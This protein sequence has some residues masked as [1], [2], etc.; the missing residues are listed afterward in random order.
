ML[1]IPLIPLKNNFQN[2]SKDIKEG[3]WLSILVINIYPSD[4]LQNCI[5]QKDHENCK[6][7]FGAVYG[8][9]LPGP[10]SVVHSSMFLL[11]QHNEG[12]IDR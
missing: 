12:E 4:I 5:G 9:S 11:R 3:C 10:T 6:I 2:F 1:S 8:L 7:Y